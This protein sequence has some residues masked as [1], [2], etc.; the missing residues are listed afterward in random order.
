M[1][2][3]IISLLAAAAL[4]C[5]AFAMPA[6]AAPAREIDT[7]GFAAEMLALVN[8]EREKEGLA[9]LGSLDSLTAAAQ[10]RAEEIAVWFDHTRPGGRGCF[11]V[12]D[13]YGVV[14]TS[15]G[16][17]IAAG[18]NS[19]ADA[20]DGWMKSSGHRQN[21]LGDFHRMGVGVYVKKGTVYWVQLFIREGASAKPAPAWKNWPPVVQELARVVLFGWIWM[22]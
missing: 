12:L 16:E 7:S 21:I 5:G 22:K 3:R 9:H 20:V 13:D 15:K 11:T 8:A 10:K 17:N 14:S 1:K 6:A 4:L 18:Y 2:K 19:P